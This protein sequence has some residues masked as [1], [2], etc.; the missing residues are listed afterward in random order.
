MS[1]VIRR[2]NALISSLSVATPEILAQALTPTFTL[3]QLYVPQ[4]TGA[5]LDS[6]RLEVTNVKGFAR[7]EIVY[8]NAKAWYAALVHEFVWLNH[9]FPTQAKYLQAAM[10]QTA[11][12]FLDEIAKNYTDIMLS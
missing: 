6:G 8:G 12:N 5:L 9:E 1:D 10:E 2:Y 3:S 4:K 11:D 7:A